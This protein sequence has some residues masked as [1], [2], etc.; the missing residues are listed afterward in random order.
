MLRV[1]R[2]LNVP[3]RGPCTQC[4]RA[5]LVRVPPRLLPPDLAAAAAAP[6]SA[7]ASAADAGLTT[8]ALLSGPAAAQPGPAPLDADAGAA[9]VP[10]MVVG[11]PRLATSSALPD[12][13][14]ATTVSFATG[15]DG[16]VAADQAGARP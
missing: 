1:G 9:P 8:V 11:G 15:L 14:G 12:A 2:T 10:S 13:G 16:G 5:P 6:V 4:P 7:E 3:L